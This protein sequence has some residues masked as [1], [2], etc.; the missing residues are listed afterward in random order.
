MTASRTRIFRQAGRELALAVSLTAL[1][2]TQS[3]AFSAAPQQ[4][5]TD[6]PGSGREDQQGRG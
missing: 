3:Y 4:M 2:L 6:G 1:S 5:C